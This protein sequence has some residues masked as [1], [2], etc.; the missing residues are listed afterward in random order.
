M[1]MVM[2]E[3]NTHNFSSKLIDSEADTHPTRVQTNVGLVL[4]F[5]N[6]ITTGIKTGGS[7]DPTSL[8]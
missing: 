2:R 5:P 3:N 6:G 7:K 8:V 4:R 1:M